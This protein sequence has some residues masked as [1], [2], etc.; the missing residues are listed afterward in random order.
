MLKKEGYNKE[1]DYWSIGVVL[2]EMLIG[3][4]PFYADDALRTC[5]KILNWRETLKFPAEAEVSW[6]AKNLI[7]SLLCEPEH[8]LGS[9]RGID[10]FKEHP[11]FAGVDWDSLH[12]TKPPF[13]P[14]LRSDT[15]VR[16]F[17]EYPPVA[18][19]MADERRHLC[20]KEFFGFT[21]KR[22][23][24][25]TARKGLSMSMFSPEEAE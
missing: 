16:Y 5:R 10:E 4:P 20:E 17:D 12:S 25:G 19:G 24:E 7:Q 6:A 3:F 13:V 23:N 1:C 14:H 2:F 8:R 18:E 15:D 21:W 9:K 22:A 11:F